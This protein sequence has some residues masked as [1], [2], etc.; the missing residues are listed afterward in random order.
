MNISQPQRP[1]LRVHDENMPPPL[2]PGKTLHQR[3]K[4]VPAFSSMQNGVSKIV[5]AAGIMPTKKILGE[6]N[7]NQRLLQPAKD[8]SIIGKK[9]ITEDIMKLA[10]ICGGRPDW[11]K[12]R[13]VRAKSVFGEQMAEYRLGGYKEG[14]E[15]VSRIRPRQTSP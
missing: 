2:L 5:Q 14:A 3:T 9:V 4:S 1:R 10:G 11:R 6:V 12:Y 8:D 7:A 15:A 13:S